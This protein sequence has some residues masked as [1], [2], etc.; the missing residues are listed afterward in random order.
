MNFVYEERSSDL[1]FVETIWRTEDTADGMY[2]AAADGAWD[3]TF[4]ERGGQHR[5]LLS[6]PSSRATPVPYQAGNRNFGVRFSP[7]VFMPALA[8]MNMVDVTDAQKTKQRFWLQGESWELPTFD[9]VD[10]F[11]AKLARLNMLAKD[12]IVA[13]VLA[14]HRPPI[15]DR[16]IQR[17]FMYSIGLPPRHVQNIH[18]ANRA[19]E[20]LQQGT[21]I[22]D[23]ILE[24]GYADQAHLTRQVKHVSGRT[25]G[26]ILRVV[27]ACRLRSIQGYGPCAQMKVQN[28]KKGVD[29][30]NQTLQTQYPES[31][32]RRATRAA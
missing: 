16:S 19:V 14:G 18:R 30:G 28:Y 26:Q 20:L 15:T 10:V 12:T 5:I 23:V 27:E 2:L 17:H 32:A 21:S 31:S 25:P 6:G 8:A 7:G 1:P 3:I 29:Y 4:T 24:L 13:A 11:L 9:N 22:G